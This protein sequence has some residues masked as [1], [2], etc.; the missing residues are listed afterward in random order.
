MAVVDRAF[1][2]LDEY[3]LSKLIANWREDVWQHAS[4]LL[5]IQD[6]TRRKRISQN[7]KEPC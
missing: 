2:R 7:W 1:G 3:L 4:A 5:E 6:E